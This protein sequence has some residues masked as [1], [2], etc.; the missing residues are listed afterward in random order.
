MR[1]DDH[2]SHIRRKSSHGALF[3]NATD[4]EK[5]WDFP[6]RTKQQAFID[7][8]INDPRAVL[9]KAKIINLISKKKYDNNLIIKRS[10][11]KLHEDS[12]RKSFSKINMPINLL[13]IDA[14]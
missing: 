5:K 7:T 2:L 14:K 8:I 13:Q 10:T 3:G 9:I 11:Q 6:H 4:K 12:R 1:L